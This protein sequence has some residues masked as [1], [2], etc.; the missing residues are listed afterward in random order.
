MFEHYKTKKRVG[1]YVHIFIKGSSI[2]HANPYLNSDFE[3]IIFIKT[4]C[5][6]THK[7]SPKTINNIFEVNI[8][9]RIIDLYK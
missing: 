4:C 9:Y 5:E 2:A 1:I 3:R 6:V 8:I 7:T